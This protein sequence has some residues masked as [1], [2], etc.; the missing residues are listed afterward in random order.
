MGNPA[1]ELKLIV[2]DM[3]NDEFTLE[4]INKLMYAT[5][6]KNEDTREKLQISRIGVVSGFLHINEEIEV[7]VKYM[8]DLEQYTKKEFEQK[9]TLIQE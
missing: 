6:L 2:N 3:F 5:L 7:V 4:E 1:A 9:L 8:D